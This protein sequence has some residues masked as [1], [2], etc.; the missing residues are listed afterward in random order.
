MTIRSKLILSV[1]FFCIITFV[2]AITLFVTFRQTN[3]LN[4]R[5]DHSGEATP[6]SS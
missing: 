2:V 5:E 6:G 4:A 1:I 3:E